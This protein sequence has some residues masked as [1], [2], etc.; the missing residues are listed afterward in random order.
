MS[1]QPKTNK[2]SLSDRKKAWSK[3]HAIEG[4]P[5]DIWR[6]DAWGNIINWQEFGSKG[7]TYGWGIIN[8]PQP[9]HIGQDD[10]NHM[11]PAHWKMLD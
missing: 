11:Q 1:Q 6:R 4:H 5:P 9:N 2:M 10:I 3:G 8:Q 7:S